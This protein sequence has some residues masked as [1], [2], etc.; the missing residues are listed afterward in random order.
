MTFIATF[1]FD[2]V[3]FI[4]RIDALDLLSDPIQPLRSLAGL[5][6]RCF[7]LALEEVLQHK[8]AKFLLRQLRTLLFPE[9]IPS[10][11]IQDHQLLIELIDFIFDFTF[12][13]CIVRPLRRH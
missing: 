10:L 9:H 12:I 2:I 6:C 11:N 3:C 4:N 8:R 5:R 1:E 13:L 7:G